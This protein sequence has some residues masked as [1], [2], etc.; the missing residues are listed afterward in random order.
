[1]RG[2]STRCGGAREAFVFFFSL[3]NVS[4]FSAIVVDTSEMRIFRRK[5]DF[6]LHEDYTKQRTAVCLSVCLVNE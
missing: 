2:I 5:K 1:M 6:H 4:L 3:S